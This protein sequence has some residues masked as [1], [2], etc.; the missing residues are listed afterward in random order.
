M[1]R[2]PT[3]QAA[4]A[5]HTAAAAAAAAPPQPPPPPQTQG[6][7]ELV[8][9]ASVGSSGSPGTFPGQVPLPVPMP[10]SDAAGSG[11]PGQ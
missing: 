6:A 7:Q 5:K 3:V 4:I 8:G 9:R 11:F 10:G 1:K 2:L